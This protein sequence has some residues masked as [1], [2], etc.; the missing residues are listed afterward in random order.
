MRKARD[1]RP[2]PFSKDRVHPGD[3]GHLLMA[4]T[5]LAALGAKAPDEPLA[6]IKS[7]PL[8][9][10]V[11]Q[12][13]ALRSA[14]W[15][16]HVGYTREKTVT[17]EPLGAAEADAAKLQERIDAIRRKKRPRPGPDHPPAFEG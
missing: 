12:K 7:D 8:H 3:H 10:L 17:P 6:T 4:R 11:E 13:R 16:R 1:A 9:K 2:E 14:A 15:M 5:I